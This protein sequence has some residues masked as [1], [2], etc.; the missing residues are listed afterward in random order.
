MAD[1]KTSSHILPVIRDEPASQPGSKEEERKFR[2]D[3]YWYLS[4]R[5]SLACKHC[6]V[7]SSPWVDTSD[8]LDT[9]DCLRVVEQMA[10]LNVRTAILTGG[11]ALMRPDI[12]TIIRAIADAGMFVGLESNGIK[13]TEA[14]LEVAKELQ[15]RRRFSMTVS[16]DGGNAASHDMVRGTG[17][18]DRTLRNLH[19]LNEAGIR[20]DVQAVWNR[21][22]WS[23]LP[24]LVRHAQ[25]LRPHLRTLMMGFLNPVGRGQ[26]IM[27]ELGLHGNDVKAV[28]EL[29]ERERSRFEGH[30]LVKLPP[31]A[32]PPKHITTVR[33]DPKV[34]GCTT[35]QFPLLGVLPN[36]DVTVCALS[37][38]NQDLYF[39]NVKEGRLKEMWQ[40]A[41][42][43]LL[44]SEYVAADHLSGICGDC[45]W[46]DICK[47]SCRAWAYESGGSFDAPF[48]ICQQMADDGT[49]P[50]AYRRS[51]SQVRPPV[52]GDV[53]MPGCAC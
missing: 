5:C 23:S 28:F 45:V 15:E 14:F 39:G 30:I 53:Q 19:R 27:G 47:G 34:H 7:F 31:A 38:E 11:E 32:I 3:I 16:L 37:R 12:L 10:E 50:L 43:D 26:G 4:F 17:S 21:K 18:F 46:S 44:R 2:P 9:D 6:S 52:T 36:G 24:D 13:F 8:D 25:E 22:S 49:F 48:P 41:R 29:L 33:K 35:C 1:L 40:R 20:F 51:A 42:M